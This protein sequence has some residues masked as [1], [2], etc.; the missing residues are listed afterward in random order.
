M[1]PLAAWPWGAD[2]EMPLRL[3]V[4]GIMLIATVLARTGGVLPRPV[5]LALAGCVL[6][7]VV[8]ALAGRTP[9]L[10]LLG[11]YQ[12]YEGLPL[13]LGYAAALWAG[14]RLLGP[15]RPRIRGH[16]ATALV[17]STHVILLWALVELL[18]DPDRRLVTP[19]GN[20]TLVGLWGVLAAAVL[21]WAGL[22]VRSRL[23]L[24]GAVSGLL[25]VALSASRGAWLGLLAV[26]ALSAVLGRRAVRIRWWWPVVPVLM[27]VTVGAVTPMVR[28]RLLGTSPLARATVSGRLLMWS[29]TLQLVGDHPLTGVGP[30][31]FVDEIGRYHSAAWQAAAGPVAPPDS[32]HLVLFQVA[33][34]TGAV[35]VVAVAAL[36]V[37]VLGS[38]RRVLADHDAWS[39]A[40][41]TAGVGLGVGYLTTFTDPVLVV[42][43]LFV[44]G[45]ALSRPAPAPAP[46]SR[47]PT[48]ALA[49]SIAGLTIASAGS[50]L[51]SEAALA[52]AVRSDDD[53]R[54]VRSARL[55]SRVRL[56]DPDVAVRAGH[57]LVAKGRPE[58]LLAAWSLLE[59]ACPR[60]PGSVVC[61]QTL[62]DAYDLAGEPGAALQ[63]LT[64]A[65]PLDP[66]NVETL[67]RTGVALS[68][69]GRPAEAEQTFRQAAGLR[70]SAAEPW[71]NLA[72][73]MRQQGREAE[74]GAAEARARALRRRR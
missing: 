43:G 64:G 10:S 67:L 26:L 8:A 12:R 59:P 62:A 65:L 35:G 41:A 53:T 49:G 61:R 29:E 72:H 37:A 33:A 28:D 32:P 57:V 18:R 73:L 1:L 44:L 38:L 30:S 69:L 24:S 42:V 20:A 40:A 22:A 50:L 16:L 70:P 34:A 31:R 27:V 6:A 71:D 74:A 63:T 58:G 4:I 9:L 52:D 11:R 47:W 55:A 13:V 48:R 36:A 66:F 15:S 7:F 23:L 51:V 14:A 60:L 2:P 46:R 68:E 21:G 54:A 56:S 3:V 39:G 5:R 17:A 45:G 25:L 19:L